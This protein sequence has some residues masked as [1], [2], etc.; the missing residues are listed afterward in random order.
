ME[1]FKNLKFAWNYA[2]N[3]KKN[4]I[5]FIIV[6]I[7]IIVI[8]V[9]V[10]ILS[11]KIIVY[12]T[13]NEFHQLLLIAF[14]ILLIEWFRNVCNYF[15]RHNSNILF[16]ETYINLQTCLGKEILKIENKD[17]DSTGSGLFIQ[18]LT[19]DTS[20]LSD[21]FPMLIDFLTNIVTDIGIFVAIFII[22]KVVFIYMMIATIILYLIERKRVKLRNDND[23]EFSKMNEKF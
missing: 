19:N 1:F 7:L 18:R 23:K 4:L 12:L 16:R 9:V 3:Q 15:K 14:V 21:I 8:S 22:N 2:K 13:D 20:K 6:N 11:A 10:P 5:W 17:I